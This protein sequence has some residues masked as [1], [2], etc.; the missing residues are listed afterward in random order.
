MT[1]EGNTGLPEQVMDA[2]Q[3]NQ[4]LQ[5]H[6]TQLENDLRLAAEIGKQL[7][8]TNQDLTQ[9]IENSAREYTK[10]IEVSVICL[11]LECWI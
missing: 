9:Q 5:K 11:L 8:T 1:S 7:L 2:E 4:K 3:Y 10:K 6:V